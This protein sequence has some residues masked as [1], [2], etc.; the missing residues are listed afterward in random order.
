MAVAYTVKAGHQ[1]ALQLLPNLEREERIFHGVLALSFSG[2][3]S[4]FVS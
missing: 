2:V 4:P 1:G 3:R